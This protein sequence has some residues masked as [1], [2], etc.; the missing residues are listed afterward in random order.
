MAMTLVPAIMQQWNTLNT[1]LLGYI[2]KLQRWYDSAMNYAGIMS[3]ATPTTEERMGGYQPEPADGRARDPH[4]RRRAMGGKQDFRALLARAPG[5]I[6]PIDRSAIH[7]GRRI[8][9][10]HSRSGSL[11]FRWRQAECI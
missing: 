1:N 6:A 5:I 4:I 3:V 7:D 8:A 11:P 2:E 9:A 10:R